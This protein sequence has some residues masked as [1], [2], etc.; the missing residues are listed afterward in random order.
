MGRFETRWLAAEN[1]LS[2]LEGEIDIPG[3]A[4]TAVADLGSWQP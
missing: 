1:I 3:P 2:T 4:R